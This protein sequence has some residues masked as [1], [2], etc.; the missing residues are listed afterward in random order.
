MNR[1]RRSD[2]APLLNSITQLGDSHSE[3]LALFFSELD[4]VPKDLGSFEGVC[5]SW[6]QV[7]Q[8]RPEQWRRAALLQ[9]PLIA[10]LRTLSPHRAWRQLHRQQVEGRRAKPAPITKLTRRRLHSDRSSYKV[11][12][13]LLRAGH[14]S[15]GACLK[16]FPVSGSRSQMVVHM[17]TLVGAWQHSDELEMRLCIF[18]KRDNRIFVLHSGEKAVGLE[19]SE[20]M[21]VED[22][23]STWQFV[24]KY[25][26]AG[27]HPWVCGSSC[28]FEVTVSRCLG[29][30]FEQVKAGHVTVDIMADEVVLPHGGVDGRDTKRTVESLLDR[31][32]GLDGW[33]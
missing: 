28:K 14:H 9:F 24:E 2:G 1:R 31:L 11:G 26:S 15:L 23:L 4:A 20:D 3:L 7:A 32:E 16:E 18:R 29:V 10:A 21:L 6:R 8:S 22:H 12:F 33:V 17:D 19:W 13:E 30:T 25:R 27:G 5:R